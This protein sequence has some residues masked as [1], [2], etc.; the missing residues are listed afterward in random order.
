MPGTSASQVSKLCECVA[1]N[2]TPAPVGALIT[3]GTSICP[4]DMYRRFADML[5]IWS[6][7]TSAKLIDISSTI[8]RNP[9]LAAPT[10]AP[11]NA[12]S[13]IGVSLMRRAPYFSMKPFVTE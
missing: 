11:T 12:A 13:E 6:N 2:C 10:P 7:A 9:T 3:I 4:P 8:G 5:T 1:P